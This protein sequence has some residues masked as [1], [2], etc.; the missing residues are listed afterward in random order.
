MRNKLLCGG[1]LL[2]SSLTPVAQV[3]KPRANASLLQDASQAM[4]AGKLSLAEKDLQSV[5]R[6]APEDYRALDLLGVVRV[7]QQRESEAEELFLR[8]IQKTAARRK[9]FSSCAKPYAWTPPVATPL[10]L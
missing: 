10:T 6:T 3:P 9:P 2:L 7:L 8:A 5:L 1:V 4:T